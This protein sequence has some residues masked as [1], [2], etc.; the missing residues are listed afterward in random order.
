M[1]NAGRTSGAHWLSLAPPTSP[2][3]GQSTP[4]P[5]RILS[6]TLTSAL[7][8]EDGAALPLALAPADR[9]D[10]TAPGLSALL[11]RTE[12]LTRPSRECYNRAA[13]ISPEV[14]MRPYRLVDEALDDDEEEY[15][16]VVPIGA[17]G[18]SRATP[19][20]V[21]PRARP[22][23]PRETVV[24]AAPPR[25][26]PSPLAAPR[27]GLTRTHQ[28]MI[29]SFVIICV[30]MILGMALVRVWDEA[31]RAVAALPPEGSTS[32]SRVTSAPPVPAAP[33]APVEEASPQAAGSVTTEIRVLQP[34]YTVAPG[35][36]LGI[37]ARRHGTTVEALAAVNNLENR[38]SLS[39]GQKLIIP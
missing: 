6:D 33:P 19:F 35:D 38:N 5:D 18:R 16:R 2:S 28:L 22:W 12:G 32:P 37:I 1:E 14:R 13:P 7:D 21:G 24:P 23:Q 25:V 31:S 30:G 4:P 8:A 20:S 34:N 3:D 15:P 9:A 26:S 10:P 27:A 17:G 11:V 29:A 36:T 39:V